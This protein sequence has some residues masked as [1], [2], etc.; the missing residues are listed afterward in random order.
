VLAL[1]LA[2]SPARAQRPDAAARQAE[3]VRIA[4]ARLAA[5]DTLGALAAV[6]SV[7]ERDGNT[8]GLETVRLTAER[9]GA[10]LRRYPPPA[11]RRLIVRTARRLLRLDP[12]S[13]LALE[14]L[15]DDALATVLFF[16]DR[17]ARFGLTMATTPAEASPRLR[18]SR[19]D[20]GQR[21]AGA[22]LVD[23]TEPARDAAR[24]A[25]SLL[26]SLLAVDAPRAAPYVVAL[27]VAERRWGRLDSLAGRLQ[28][29]TW[30]GLAGGLA[31]WRLGRT[32]D[33]ER[34]FASGLAALSLAERTR[35]ES[36]EALLPPDSLA[37][38]QA[39][40][41]GVAR[42]FW[43]REDPRRITAASERRLEHLARVLEADALFGRP[44][45]DLFSDRPRRGAETDRG[46]VWVRYGRPD[47][48]AG[49]TP[50]DSAPAYARD[51]LAAFVVWEY[52]RLDGG[53]RFV[54]DD[55]ARS[56]RYRTYSP[57][58]SAYATPTGRASAD[59][60]VTQDRVLQRD[61][62]QTYAD[63]L[64]GDLALVVARFRGTDGQPEAVAAFTVPPGAR[65][66]VFVDGRRAAE[67]GAAVV[68]LT[69]RPATVRAEW[70][71]PAPERFAAAEARV[72]PL[73]AGFG[74]SDLL[75]VGGDGPGVV[76]R[77]ERIVPLVA[78]TL[79]R[80]ARVA[81]Y[82]EVYGL[83]LRDG[84]TDAEAEVGLVPAET[85]SG[86]RRA[87][88][89]LFGRPRPSGVAT[90]VEIQGSDPTDAVA[91]ALDA[92]GLPPGRY[93]LVLRL[94]D[95]PGGRTAEASREIVLRE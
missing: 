29:P 49:F 19:F 10:G 2:A 53:T 60:H 43:A 16:R 14:T 18:G 1:V 65:A 32:D 51:E 42:R 36:V 20:L 46:R 40:P 56:G 4:E 90:A 59:D 34:A 78:D 30:T 83:T 47:R 52:D 27:A 68:A 94:A 28:N 37:A 48:E 63:T 57:P 45:G 5:G 64:A 23:R 50:D 33:A 81:V 71:A 21:A 55:A 22:P 44:L 24:T 39:D 84:R 92:S 15:A 75:L 11:R 9:T 58:S 6:R 25:S 26:D 86:L 31:A 69:G 80:G 87:A 66:A 85:G 73:A 88:A 95:R 67:A 8:A 77:G 12:S 74:L 38:F 35:F 41:D 93:R 54:F 70:L 72:E 62:P 17:G 91:L 79:A 82:A 76:R 61:A 7:Q 13:P 3:A 89:R